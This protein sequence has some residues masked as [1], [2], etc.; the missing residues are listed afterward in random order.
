MCRTKWRG[1]MFEDHREMG[2]PIPHGAKQTNKDTYHEIY[3]GCT[4]V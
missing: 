3:H 1:F 2:L 4:F